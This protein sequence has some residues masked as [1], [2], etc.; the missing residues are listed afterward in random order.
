LNIAEDEVLDKLEAGRGIG[1]D[2]SVGEGTFGFCLSVFDKC[3]GP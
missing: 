1:L 2:L 3:D